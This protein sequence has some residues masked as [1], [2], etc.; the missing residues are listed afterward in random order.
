[1]KKLTITLSLLVISVLCNS[2]V[3]AGNLPGPMV[4]VV[5]PATRSAQ[6]DE[7][8]ARPFYYRNWIRRMDSETSTTTAAP[9]TSTVKVDTPDLIFAEFESDGHMKKSI[10]KLLEK[11]RVETKTSTTFQPIYVPDEEFQPVAQIT[12][13][14]LPLPTE[15]PDQKETEESKYFEM[16][17]KFYNIAPTTYTQTTSPTTT[18][19]KIPTTTSTQATP[20]NVENIWHIIDSEKS[21]QHSGNWEEV[22]IGTNEEES[23]SEIQLQTNTDDHI[24]EDNKE[25]NEDDGVFTDFA[26]PG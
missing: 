26:V 12:N 11:E 20:S 6:N 5:T 23:K 16:Y 2:K 4:Y 18:T 1:M 10:R 17:N 7:G 19:T 25:D 21:N 15:K 3:S 9:T 8:R 24:I 13:Y 14:G 22:P